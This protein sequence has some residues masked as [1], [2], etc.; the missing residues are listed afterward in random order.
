MGLERIVVEREAV[1]KI[2]AGDRCGTCRR[3]RKMRVGIARFGNDVHPRGAGDVHDCSVFGKAVHEQRRHESVARVLGGAREQRA[4]C[5]APTMLGQDRNAELRDVVT[6]GDVSDANQRKRV[7]EY[8]NTA[9][10]PRS[11]SST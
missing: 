9:S 4:P 3:Q 6:E 8:P 1:G 5:T 11:I 10:R 7:V 2:L